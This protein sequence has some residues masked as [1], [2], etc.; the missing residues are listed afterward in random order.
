MN[1]KWFPTVGERAV[2]KVDEPS[3]SLL[4]K[5]DIVLVLKIVAGGKTV[6]VVRDEKNADI[7]WFV[8]PFQLD[9]V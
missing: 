6:E 3:N 7:V 8:S 1:Q 2:V 4:K 9:Q 5:G